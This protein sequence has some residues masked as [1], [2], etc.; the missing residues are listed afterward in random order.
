MSKKNL[1]IKDVKDKK[2]KLEIDI[3]KM[4]KDFEKECGIKVSYINTHRKSEDAVPSITEEGPITDIEVSMD[5]DLI[6]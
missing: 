5:L 1:T 4:V 6:Y 3:L 2:S